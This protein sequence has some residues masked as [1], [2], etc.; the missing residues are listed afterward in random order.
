LVINKRWRWVGILA[1]LLMLG[2]VS[3][4]Q[5]VSFSDISGHWAKD[6]IIDLADQGYIK[7]YTDKT[8]KPDNSM[9]RAEFLT[10]LMN[11][12]E[13]KSSTYTTNSFNDIS[14]H[15]AKDTINEAVRQGIIVKSEYG[16]N[17][18]PDKIIKRD[19]TSAMMVR[20]LG[21][22]PDKG[23][24]TFKDASSIEKSL[25]RDY[26]KTAYDL[27]LISGFNDGTFRPSESVTR[28]QACS[29]VIRFQGKQTTTGISTGSISSLQIG[30]TTYSLLNTPIY[31]KVG[32]TEILAVNLTVKSGVLILN[33]AYSFPLNTS[34]GNP[35][36]V[37]N[38]NLYEV[39]SLSLSQQTLVAA[40]GSVKLNKL[41]F[42]GFK[43]NPE[44]V[45]L[46]VGTTDSGY[47]LSDMEIVDQYTIVID[48][49]TINLRTT[50]VSITP[51]SDY[52]AINRIVMGYGDTTLELEETDPVVYSR[53]RLSDIQDIYIDGD[54]INL[55]NISR[56]DF[57][58]NN[59]MYTLSELSIDASGS[60]KAD[61][62]TYLPED[63]TLIMWGEYYPLEEVVIYRQKIIF[64][65]DKAISGSMVLIDDKYYDTD[66]VQI[67]MDKKYYDLDKVLVVSRNQ[68]RIE[69]RQYKLD[70]KFALR[71]NNKL[72]NIDRIDYD[73]TLN[74]VVIDT[75]D[76][77]GIIDSS[78][79]PDTIVFYLD[80]SLLKRGT[81]S[82]VRIYADGA[83]WY[84]DEISLIDSTRFSADNS[85][86][87]TIGALV[88]INSTRYEVI[89]TTWQGSNNQFRFYLEE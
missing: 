47:Y 86:Y 17:F 11:S 65:C 33:G 78:S 3:Q 25:Y 56:L 9:T 66:D 49:K 44:F 35:K 68:M 74:I 1:I 51:S 84:F 87:R 5:A 14:K 20:A 73:S 63:V 76:Y 42:A 10:I 46:Y 41:L 52:Y 26:I 32:D 58:I 80:G 2:S 72:Y 37:V 89:D 7:G 48:G 19:E 67:V 71:V 61:S 53:T 34:T 55:T 36:I 39:K 4:V 38:N 77:S 60:I 85:S 83:W 69:G 22:S 81:D 40:T 12:M 21:K 88:R 16:T 45:N 23:Q 28:A 82:S 18:A 62:K 64:Y 50:S 54:P 24:I 6:T 57:V 43:Y 13:V 59:S 15:W 79:Q 29:L 30:G 75:G 31:F 27:G 70:S 8:F